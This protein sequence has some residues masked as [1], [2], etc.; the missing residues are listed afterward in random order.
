MVYKNNYS[1]TGICRSSHTIWVNCVLHY[2]KGEKYSDI[3]IDI[4]IGVIAGIIIAEIRQEED[5]VRTF[6]AGYTGLMKWT[7]RI[8][9]KE[10]KKKRPSYK[11]KW[12][13]Q[14]ELLK[15]SKIVS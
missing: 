6:L 13:M 8:E 14:I 2:S 11:L 3:A 5:R 9:G 4:W 12:E 15:N 10:R 7:K 1:G